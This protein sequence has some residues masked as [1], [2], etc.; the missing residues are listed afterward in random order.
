MISGNAFAYDGTVTEND[1]EGLP[2][3]N[4]LKEYINNYKNHMKRI[5]VEPS[6]IIVKIDKMLKGES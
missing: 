5:E 6:E 2:F 1:F 3:E 4:I